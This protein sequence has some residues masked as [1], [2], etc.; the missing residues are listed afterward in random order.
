MLYMLT[1]IEN[2][3]VSAVIYKY[4]FRFENGWILINKSGNLR[5]FSA[6]TC[7]QSFKTVLCPFHCDSA[8]RQVCLHRKPP[9]CQFRNLPIFTVKKCISMYIFLNKQTYTGRPIILSR[10][11]FLHINNYFYQR[12]NQ[13]IHS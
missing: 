1:R 2:A 10:S 6:A 11:A 12:R 4:I 13:R 3:D 8:D 7:R 9:V 5:M